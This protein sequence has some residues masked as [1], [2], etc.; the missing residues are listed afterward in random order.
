L[1]DSVQIAHQIGAD[2]EKA[3]SLVSLARMSLENAADSTAANLKKLKQAIEIFSNMGANL[4]LADAQKL[5]E[6]FL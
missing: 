1:K 2:H 6:E 3:K 5:Y 4:E